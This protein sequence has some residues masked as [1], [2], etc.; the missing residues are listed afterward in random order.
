ML[1]QAAY[2]EAVASGWMN[3]WIPELTKAEENSGKNPK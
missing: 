1:T 3:Q 2:N